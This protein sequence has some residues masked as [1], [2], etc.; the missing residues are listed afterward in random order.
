MLDLFHTVYTAGR[1]SAG[2]GAARRARPPRLASD[3]W[4]LLLRVFASEEEGTASAGM[5]GRVGNGRR[6]QYVCPGE[7]RR[8]GRGVQF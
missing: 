7:R 4:I 1:R 3:G 5:D 6:R 2:A 8:Q